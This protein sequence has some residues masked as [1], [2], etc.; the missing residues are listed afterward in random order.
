MR[1]AR[2]ISLTL[3]CALLAL[4]AGLWLGG[5]PE[6]LPEPLREVFVDDY[7]ATRAELIETI[8]QNFYREVDLD[9]LE[10]ASLK[11][12]VES[13]GDR[14]SHYFTPEETA[15][16][17]E[18]LDG[19][20]E[21]V[22]MT[23]DESDEGLL[24]VSVFDDSPAE[25]AGIRPDDVIV[26]VDGRPLRGV[27]VDVA[28]ARIKGEAGT[29]VRLTVLRP[30][31]GRQRTL[32][33][34]RERI[35][36]PLTDARLR[37]VGGEPVG[38]VA[39][40]S[41]SSGAHAQVREEVERLL[42]RGAKG[43]VLDLRDNGGGLLQE[44]VLVA[45]V[46]I[47]EGVIVS[48]D[49]RSRP[50]RVFEARGDAID[51]DVPMVVLV[52]RGTASAA[53][54]VAG[55]LRD[56]RRATVVGTPTFGKGVFQEVEPLDNGGALDLTVGQYF[57]PKGDNLTDNGIRPQVRARDLPRTRRDEAMAVALET[58]RGKLR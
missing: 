53:E 35:A 2:T 58:L 50:R 23:V 37:R 33:V 7:D 30:D 16:L 44:G 28:T 43:I 57:L 49:G 29:T 56:H 46:F 10:E 31:T 32:T 38:V 1:A 18:S 34:R 22:G 17:Q 14:Y 19:E 26:R 15:A 13:L 55:A 3:L 27:P 5:H 9:D 20:F 21:G 25:R 51:E 12:I 11:G 54:I 48:T 52:N 41:F 36:V 4:L 24:V 47:D 42:R 45:S 6:R 8:E 40:S 39:L